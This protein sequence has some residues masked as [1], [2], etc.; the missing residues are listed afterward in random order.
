VSELWNVTNL[1][2]LHLKKHHSP[3]ETIIGEIIIEERF[4]H[5]A[6]Q[7]LPI[8]VKEII[9]KIFVCD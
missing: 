5:Q 7:C 4:E 2:D 3:I 9:R 6:K 1:R 8:E